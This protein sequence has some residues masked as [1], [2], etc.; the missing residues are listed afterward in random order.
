MKADGTEA[1]APQYEE[2]ESCVNG[3]ITVKK[4]GENGKTLYGVYTV[5]NK[6]VIPFGKYDETEAPMY[7]DGYIVV[8]KNDLKGIA[9]KEGNAFVEPKYKEI[10]GFNIVYLLLTDAFH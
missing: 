2:I 9:D 1:I 7:T 3:M 6:E 5:E 8:E 10:I 4:T